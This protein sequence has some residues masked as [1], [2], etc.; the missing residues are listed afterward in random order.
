MPTT[1][2]SKRL[3]RAGWQAAFC[4]PGAHRRGPLIDMIGGMAIAVETFDSRDQLDERLPIAS[5]PIFF[6]VY[7]KVPHHATSGV[8]TTSAQDHFNAIDCRCAVVVTDAEGRWRHSVDVT[9]SERIATTRHSTIIGFD[10]SESLQVRLDSDLPLTD[11]QL[12]IEFSPSPAAMPADLLPALELLVALTEDTQLGL[13]SY[14]SSRWAAQPAPVSPETSPPPEEYLRTVRMLAAIQR[15]LGDPFPMPER[16]TAEDT[17]AI[18]RLHRLLQGETLRGTWTGARI[19]LDRTSLATLQAVTEPYGAL[20]EFSTTLQVHV[21]GHEVSIE[22]VQY[23]LMEIGLAGVTEGERAADNVLVTLK[24]GEN[25]RY[26]LRLLER[27]E[28]VPTDSGSGRHDTGSLDAYAGLWIAQADAE[29]IV[30]GNSP[31]EVLAALNE[32]GR[33]GAI[34]RV[35]ASKEEADSLTVGL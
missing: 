1:S 3:R 2:W 33:K 35:P 30:S 4:N 29:I 34:W 15:S 25:A 10:E 6:P 31:V 18:H 32:T 11:V 16:I 22:P 13:W 28:P 9:F 26:E 5:T 20:F 21:G 14:G 23:R 7:I 17:R 24:P 27:L 19:A 8:I 12:N